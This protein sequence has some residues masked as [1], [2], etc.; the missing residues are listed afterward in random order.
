MKSKQDKSP[1]DPLTSEGKKEII[2]KFTPPTG[3]LRSILPAALIGGILCGGAEALRRYYLY[4]G[5]GDKSSYLY[6]S[7]TFI[8]LSALLTALGIFDRIAR[9]A[10]AG[11]LTP[12]TGFANSVVSAC[13]DSRNE[14][15]IVGVG[16]KL[17]TVAGPVIAYGVLSS[18]LYGLV[19]LL[20]PYLKF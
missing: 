15:H 20:I 17:F 19:Y 13:I 11:V 16:S 18:A 1:P 12:I 7:L 10:G 3:K 5:S 4:L 8:A 9:F 14:G 6:I 2:K